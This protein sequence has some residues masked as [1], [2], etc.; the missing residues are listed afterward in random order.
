M[1]QISSLGSGEDG[2]A[3]GENGGSAYNEEPPRTHVQ[4]SVSRIEVTLS[5]QRK[6]AVNRSEKNTSHWR[7]RLLKETPPA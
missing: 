6:L 7:A 1:G 5:R 4:G 3:A 2:R